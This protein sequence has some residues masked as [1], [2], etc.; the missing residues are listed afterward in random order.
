MTRKYTQHKMV[1]GS[2]YY[3]HLGCN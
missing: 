2:V 1:L 3:S